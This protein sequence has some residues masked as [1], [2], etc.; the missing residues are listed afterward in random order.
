MSYDISDFSN[1][2]I[3]ITDGWREWYI[4]KFRIAMVVDEPYITVYWT[5]TEK[6]RSGIRRELTM[7]YQDVTFGYSSPS[8]AGEVELTL[9]IYID[10]GFGGGGG[11][12]DLA[13]TL[14]IGNTTGGTDIV[15]SSGDEIQITDATA[16]RIAGI[17]ASKEVVSLDT[18]TYPSLAELS[19]VKGVTSALQT[20]INAKLTDSDA[21][22]GARINA[23]SAAV[24][25][26]SDLVATAESAGSLKKI[27]WTNVKAFLKTYF[28]TLYQS[29]FT[30]ASFGDFIVALTGKTTPVDTDTMVLSDSAASD[31]AKKV[32][33]AN[34]KATLKTY[35]D[36][37]YTNNAGTVTTVS[38]T[39]ANGVSGTVANA[40]TTPAISLSLG[41]IT[42]SS[43]AAVGT[44]TGSNLSG[45]NTGNETTATLGATINGAA[46]ATPN[47]TDLVTTVDT[48]VVKKITWTNVKA[49]LKTYFDTLYQAILT[50][51]NFGDFIVALTG[52]TTPV[53]A[54]TMVISDSAASDDA[55]KV[56]LTN[57]K[58]F[59]KT[60]FDTL[61]TGIAA[62]AGG[63]LGG[64]Y[65]NPTFSNG[66]SV[67]P[68][69]TLPVNGSAA[70]TLTNQVVGAEF[71]LSTNRNIFRY[72]LTGYT[73]IRIIGRVSVG[74]ASANTPRL[75][76]MY[77]LVSG[78]F[79]T[80]IGN[81]AEIG[82]GG[83]EVSISLTNT[84][85]I[86]SG[87]VALL[88]TAK[89]DCYLTVCQIGGD[90]TADPSLGYV[91]V[92]VR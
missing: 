86:D 84:G 10:S 16:S 65:P 55:K 80:A 38:V 25:N 56:T 22:V 17:G 67:V 12:E 85:V 43:V 51:V 52:K 49:F 45:T 37:L 89:A 53:D 27:S 18:T 39:T 14:A 78:G 61:Y 15:V 3:Y 2:E 6:G 90:G 48:S 1:T 26:D 35:F 87:W 31:D 13:A 29:I 74:S 50:A 33:W 24:P 63:I 11:G 4:P 75:K 34:I 8:S 92:H 41:A 23:A 36:T 68:V 70:A 46:A 83:A 82:T 19:Y 20:Q 60:Y 66:T 69:V 88:S 64:T 42:P 91:N 47:D 44:V 79:S 81:F 40:T 5:D 59:L 58:A 77:D 32:T 73:S 28:D 7:D 62:T 9:N 76:V 30:A 21:A 71:F 54:D 57:F 72:D